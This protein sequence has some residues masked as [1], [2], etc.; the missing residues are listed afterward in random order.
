M[1]S[2][3]LLAPFNVLGPIE[4]KH[5]A[6]DFISANV[7]GFIKA[8]KRQQQSDFKL[9]KHPFSPSGIE[10]L[11]KSQEGGGS[12]GQEEQFPIVQK[13]IVCEDDVTLQNKIKF[14]WDVSTS[15]RRDSFSCVKGSKGV[16]N[17]STNEKKMWR[18]KKL[19]KCREFYLSWKKMGAERSRCIL[20][21]G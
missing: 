11:Q 10:T 8:L 1:N 7:P 15:K 16:V 4:R 9:T 5:F 12:V 21:Q 2:D 13:E 6:L 3:H 18:R 20:Q 14:L 17:N 19:L